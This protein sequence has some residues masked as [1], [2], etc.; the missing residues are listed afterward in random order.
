MFLSTIPVVSYVYVFIKLYVSIFSDF[1]FFYSY[2]L[3]FFSLFSMFFGLFGAL[4]QYKIKKLIAYSSISAV[5]YILAGLSGDTVL[6]VQYSVFYLFIY[7]LNIIPIFIIILNY[8]INNL[9][10]IDN[11]SSFYSLFYQN[12]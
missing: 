1:S 6:L 8:R 10:C 2:I 4:V 3:Y 11:I 7:V 9:N 12:K 5:G